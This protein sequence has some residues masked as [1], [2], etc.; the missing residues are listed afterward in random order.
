MRVE[1]SEQDISNLRAALNAIGHGSPLDV[2]GYGGWIE[3]V[4]KALPP[5]L[6]KPERNSEELRAAAL[7]WPAKRLDVK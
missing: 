2:I 7:D 4:R 5:T 6:M 1:L 3:N